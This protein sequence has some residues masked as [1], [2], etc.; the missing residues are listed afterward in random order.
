MVHKKHRIP[1]II[2]GCGI[3]SLSI[4]GAS[5]FFGDFT[6][7]LPIFYNPF[8]IYSSSSLFDASALLSLLPRLTVMVILEPHFNSSPA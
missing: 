4:C 3:M 6:F 7:D 5:E 1:A 2:N 8:I